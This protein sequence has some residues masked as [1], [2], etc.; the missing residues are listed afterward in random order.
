M[1]VSSAALVA[2]AGCGGSSGGT[3]TAGH[4]GESGTSG[5]AGASSAGAGGATAGAS[6]AAGAASTAGSDGGAGASVAGSDGGAGAG[7]SVAGSDG[8]AGSDAGPVAPFMTV[9]IPDALDVPTGAT[10]KFLAHGRGTQNYACV[11][12]LGTA[13]G[14]ADAAVTTYAWGPATPAANLYDVNNTQIGTHFAGPTWQSTV[15]GSDAV[16][17]KVASVA[18]TQTSA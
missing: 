1:A 9:P 8:G 5:V 15:D 13:D 3:G 18:S 14:G 4:G 10:Q 17:V 12:T 2:I 7:G 6:G 16:G 11:A